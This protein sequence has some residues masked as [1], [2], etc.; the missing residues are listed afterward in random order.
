MFEEDNI[1]KTFMVGPQT[2][3]EVTTRRID[4]TLEDVFSG[5]YE[6]ICEEFDYDKAAD[7]LIQSLNGH[8]CVIFLESLHKAS[9]RRI[10]EQWRKYSPERLE[11]DRYKKYLDFN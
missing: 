8:D 3:V 10:V 6:K 4:M 5:K 1:P 2:N 7:G 9:A 11:E